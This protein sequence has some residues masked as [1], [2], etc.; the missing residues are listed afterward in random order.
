MRDEDQAVWQAGQSSQH[1]M[2]FVLDQSPAFAVAHV[3]FVLDAMLGTD[4]VRAHL[5]RVVDGVDHNRFEVVI[6]LGD[7]L[8]SFE[9]CLPRI[10]RHLKTSK[11]LSPGSH[12]KKSEP[13]ALLANELFP[14]LG[15]PSKAAGSFVCRVRSR[16]GCFGWYVNVIRGLLVIQ[17]RVGHF[18]SKNGCVRIN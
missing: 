13:G 10:G 1:A 8:A 12:S 16:V 14:S 7:K 5:E 15:L 17:S 18:L 3:A 2:P 11:W 9:E 4:I 6:S